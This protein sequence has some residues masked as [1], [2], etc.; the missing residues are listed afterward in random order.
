MERAK[1][2]I[3]DTRTELDFGA[4]FDAAPGLYLVL[5]PNNPSYTIVFANRAYERATGTDR[6][7]IVGRG[8]FDVFPDNPDDPGASGVQNLRRSLG[9]VILTKRTHTMAAQRYDIRLPNEEGGVFEERYW[10]PTNTPVLNADGEVGF[11]IHRVEDVTE[12]VRLKRIGAEKGRLSEDLQSRADQIE[13]DLFLRGRQLEE[14]QRLLHERQ[15]VEEK[16]RAT[17]ASF[18]LAFA[19]APIGMVLLNPDGRITEVNQAFVDTIGY[20]REELTSGDSAPFTHPADVALTRKFFAW[21]R[22]GPHSTGSIEKRYVRKDG[23]ILWARASATMRRDAEGRPA[24]IIAIV[25]DITAR[26]HAEE[27]YR[28]LAESIPQMVWTATPDGMLDYVNGQGTAYFGVE[29]EVL[30]GAGW[31]E[32]VHPED[33]DLAIERWGVALQSGK[34][35][36]T[37]FRLK[38]AGDGG[39][40]WHLARARSLTGEN[41]SIVQWFGTCTDIE[42]QK[43]ADANLRQQWHAFDTALSHTPDFIYTFDLN[44]RFT[45]VNRALLALWEI[46]LE[47]ATGKN[48]FDLGYPEEL[49]GR[50]QDQIQQVIRTKQP[51]RDQT[52]FTGPSGETR[53]YDYIFAPVLDMYDRVKAVA[54]ST[55]DITAQNLAAKQIEDDRR[56]WRELFAQTPAA[57]AVLRGPEHR[58][59]WVN[60]DYVRLVGRD[61]EFLVGKTVREAVPEAQQQIYIDL[62]DRVYRTGEPFKGH[63]SFLRLVSASGVLEDYYVNFAYLPTRSVSG[64][65]DGIFAHVTDVTE[66]VIARKQVEESERQ[67]RTLAETIPHLAWMAD[68]AGNRFWYNRRWYDYTGTT[69]DEV[70]GWGWRK[71]HDAAVLPEVVKR[72]REALGTGEAFELIYPLMGADGSFRSFLTRVEPVKNKEGRVVRWFGTNTDITDQRRIENELRRMNRE[73]EEFAYVASHDLQE[74]IRMVNIYTQ[75]ILKSIGTENEKLNQYSKFVQEGVTRMEALIRGLLAF[76]RS[77]LTEELTVGAADLA[78]AFTEAVGV[79]K[80]RIS[81][82]GAVISACPLPLT[83]GDTSQMTHVFQN[84]LSNAL[85]YHRENLRPEIHIAAVRDNNNWIVSIKDNGIGFEPVYAE[86]IFGLFKRLHKDEYPGTGLGLAICKRIVERYGGR[87]WAEGR[88]GE[89]ATVCFAL[90]CVNDL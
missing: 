83:R 58:F 20:T 86:R 63:E 68:E 18:S 61:A 84:I 15:E 80:D 10:S 89:G 59:E 39:W 57:I 55:R 30:L 85:K 25:E 33:R 21:L 81:E 41:G 2:L 44:G 76:S 13:A 14:S 45:Y 47:D 9:E 40:R 82:T 65:I 24:Q 62:L 70:K 32:W 77:V 26:K 75:K 34:P 28:F 79:L 87:M 11:I 69:F 74:P 49:A 3:R 12:L 73:L 46:P 17:E 43:Q 16:L 1:H 78:A 38:R 56:R 19:K 31:L 90:P 8:L 42:E 37:A 66:M 50:L 23:Q 88:P 52:P 64:E 22:E 35:Y 5:R 54:G 67:F 29:Q 6:D 60:A 36:E 27:R 48:F 53:H 72:W 71:V 7:E 4:L 51:V